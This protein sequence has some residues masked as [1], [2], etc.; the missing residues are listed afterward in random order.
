MSEFLEIF[1]WLCAA[2]IVYAYG[3][4][5]LLIGAWGRLAN[6]Q[7][8]KRDVTPRLSLIIAAYNEEKSISEKIENALS[9][10]YPNDKLE[11]IVA[12]D[13]STDDTN[14]IVEAC[15]DARVRL[16][17]LP[18]R[19]KIFALD[20]AVQLATG[21]VLVFSDA[22]SIFM[23]Q[24]LRMLVRNFADPEVGGVCGNQFHLAGSGGD[25]SHRG[26]SLYWSYDKWL[27]TMESLTGSIVSA[28]GSIYAIRRELYRMPKCTDV[29]DDFAISTG[30]IE[31]GYR[32][33]YEG[34]AK[35]HEQ[36]ASA[37]KDEFERKIR[38]MNRGLRG[39][40]LRRSL[41]NPFRFGFYSVVLFSHKILRR[42]V[43]FFLGAMLVVNLLLIPVGALYKF[44]A[45]IQIV[46]YT[47]AVLGFFFKENKA[48]HLKLLYVPFFY[49]LA[50]AAAVV[51][52]SR[53]IR[54]RRIESWVPKREVVPK[55]S[56]VVEDEVLP[57]VHD[58]QN[59][60]S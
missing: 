37:A 47:L 35:S 17:D 59:V 60:D 46:F 27:K 44:S 39:V 53:L 58:I 26:E 22:N 41:L 10:D 7:V 21:D 31:Q 20:S 19:G 5:S 16:M 36:A 56:T 2:A 8:N 54:G 48:G 55:S 34:E 12:S 29:T 42:F 52:I 33:V 38:I 15:D 11:I 51:A 1:F 9:L 30:V 23:P 25:N 14:L 43:P 57:V 32:L 6:R 49:C 28:D 18:R 3:G 13:G 50:N 24:S 4:F 45:L 40:A